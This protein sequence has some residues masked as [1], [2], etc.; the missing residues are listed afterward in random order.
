M[1]T[2]T[3]LKLIEREVITSSP[4]V[5]FYYA[6]FSISNVFEVNFLLQ[7]RFTTC[8][9]QI[10]PGFFSKILD[11]SQLIVTIFNG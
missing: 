6:R 4:K 7:T 3:R 5:S 10:L 8:I 11:A 2:S 1:D 9:K